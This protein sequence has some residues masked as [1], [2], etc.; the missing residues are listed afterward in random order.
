[1]TSILTRIP[2]V[3]AK[4]NFRRQGFWKLS[5]YRYTDRQTDRHDR[6][7]IPRRFAG[8]QKLNYCCD[9]HRLIFE[10]QCLINTSEV[11]LM[12]TLGKLSYCTRVKTSKLRYQT[13]EM[14]A[15]A[16]AQFTYLYTYDLDLWP[17]KHVQQFPFTLLIFVPSFIDIHCPVWDRG[18]LLPLVHLLHL[19]HLFTFPFL[20]LALPIFFFC[21]PLPFLPE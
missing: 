6:N 8:G 18:T 2:C 4:M 14:Y 7:Y 11:V 9:H 1:M 17:W 16:V 21:P 13:V 5:Y 15:S 12:L 19:F 3:Y 10:G 20:S